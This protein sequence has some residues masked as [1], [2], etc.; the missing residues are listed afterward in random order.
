M[1]TNAGVPRAQSAK[2]TA[3]VLLGASIA[4]FVAGVAIA[5]L[6]AAAGVGG[7]VAMDGTGAVRSGRVAAEFP[8]SLD[9]L[10]HGGGRGTW[11]RR[12]ALR[13]AMPFYRRHF[14]A[15]DPHGGGA[16]DLRRHRHR[17]CGA[18][19]V[20]RRGPRG[21]EVDCLFR[22]RDD[23]GPGDRPGGDEYFAG[24]RGHQPAG[25]RERASGWSG[26]PR[27]RGSSWW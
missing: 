24:R 6:H 2:L 12:P 22:N 13:G 9:V 17:H 20:A 10:C 23:G 5:G 14:F 15:A 21:G 4:L 3:R 1:S 7:R 25:E 26:A 18:W 8:A 27:K 19:R 16:A 11:F